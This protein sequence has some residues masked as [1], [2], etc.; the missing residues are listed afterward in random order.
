MARD[1]DAIQRDIEQARDA[2][3]ATL[4][5][6]G[7]KANPKRFVESGKASMQEKLN[8]PRVRYALIGVGALVTIV[9]VRRLFR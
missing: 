5:E 8:D 2:L 4:D 3:A 9:V 6:L 7:T 1:P